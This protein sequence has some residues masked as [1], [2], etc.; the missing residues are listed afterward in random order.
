MF[1]NGNLQNA[2][3]MFQQHVHIIGTVDIAAIE[4]VIHLV[5]GQSI[6]IAD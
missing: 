1:V 4:R 3:R 2:T 5:G 6:R